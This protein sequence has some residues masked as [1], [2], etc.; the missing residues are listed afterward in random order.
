MIGRALALA[1]SIGLAAAPCAAADL[2]M[3]DVPGERRSGAQAGVYFAV[4]FGGERSGRA[5]AGLRLRMD[6][7]YRDA[8]GRVSRGGGADAIELRML[9]EPQP[10]LYVADMPVTGREARNNMLAGGGIL[11]I[12][13][14]GLAVV[15]AI[16]IMN[17]LDGDDDEPQQ[18]N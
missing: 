11:T 9:G 8:S 17:E 2:D 18:Q 5:Q 1:A 16:V 12:V 13:V 6:H 7:Q 15:G 10:T 14:I 4:P 3:P